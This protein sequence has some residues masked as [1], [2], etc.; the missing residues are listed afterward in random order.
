MW[1]LEDCAILFA[2]PRLAEKML[3]FTLLQS[4]SGTLP[5][6]VFIRYINAFCD[7]EYKGRAIT[8]TDEDTN[9]AISFL[10]ENITLLKVGIPSI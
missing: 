8:V 9:N 5:F 2:L 7:A 6:L 1:S 10:S 3:L 4:L